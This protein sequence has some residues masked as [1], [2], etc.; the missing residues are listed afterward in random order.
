MT[1]SLTS[2]TVMSKSAILLFCK[3]KLFNT[4]ILLL[5]T[6]TQSHGIPYDLLSLNMPFNSNGTKQ[7]FGSIVMK[8]KDNS[9][10]VLQR[11]TSTINSLHWWSS[12]VLPI[13]LLI[14][15]RVVRVGNGNAETTTYQ[16]L[17]NSLS[18]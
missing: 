4:P 3:N 1:Y 14:R 8:Q 10:S 11:T 7:L 5:P 13:E 16:T 17:W 9:S 12:M 18:G 15:D 2:I 6:S